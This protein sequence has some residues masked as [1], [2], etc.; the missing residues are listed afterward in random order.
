[1]F[2]LL[3]RIIT[4]VYPLTSQTA[5]EVLILLKQESSTAV[6]IGQLGMDYGQGVGQNM[7]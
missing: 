7:K 4:K 5:L 3:V 2:Q 6:I 1:M